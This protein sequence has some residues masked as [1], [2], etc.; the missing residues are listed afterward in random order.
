MNIKMKMANE[1]ERKEKEEEYSEAELEAIQRWFLYDRGIE[2][3]K[4]DIKPFN[5]K[6]GDPSVK[7]YYC[8]SVGCYATASMVCAMLPYCKI[9]GEKRAEMIRMLDGSWNECGHIV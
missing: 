5:L 6:E 3:E 1:K 7:N 2:I 8:T 4:E 9:H